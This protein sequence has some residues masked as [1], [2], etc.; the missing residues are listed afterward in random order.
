MI[1]AR[2]NKIENGFSVLIEKSLQGC[3]LWGMVCP[4]RTSA[5]ARNIIAEFERDTAENIITI[6]AK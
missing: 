4:T 2:I 1:T 3:Y 6:E 5:E